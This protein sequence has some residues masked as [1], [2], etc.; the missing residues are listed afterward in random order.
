M[1]QHLC[2]GRAP[3][4]TCTS[5]D[6]FPTLNVDFSGEPEDWNALSWAHNV[7]CFVLGYTS[8]L[9]AKGEDDASKVNPVK[10]RA[11]HQALLKLITTC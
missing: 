2:T 9:T 7:R 5:F 3:V 11:A 1:F 6:R 8:A 4:A 10:L